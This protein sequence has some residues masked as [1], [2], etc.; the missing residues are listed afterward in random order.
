[1]VTQTIENQT[2][3]VNPGDTVQHDGHWFSVENCVSWWCDEPLS[4][5]KMD[6]AD[7]YLYDW[8]VRPATEEEIMHAQAVAQ[9]ADEKANQERRQKAEEYR[10]QR[11]AYE[12]KLAQLRDQFQSLSKGLTKLSNTPNLANYQHEEIG[13]VAEPGFGASHVIELTRWIDGTGKTV[14]VSW[15]EPC[16]DMG[17]DYWG[18][19]TVRN[20]G[21]AQFR[22][23]QWWKQPGYGD[24]SYPGPG[25]PREELTT[26]E[27]A[28]V[29]KYE[30][31][32]RAELIRRQVLDWKGQLR[33][34]TDHREIL[35]P[36]SGKVELAQNEIVVTLPQSRLSDA[37]KHQLHLQGLAKGNARHAEAQVLPIRFLTCENAP[38]LIRDGG[39]LRLR[40]AGKLGKEVESALRVAGWQYRSKAWAAN[41]TPTAR[42]AAINAIAPVKPEAKTDKLVDAPIYFDDDGRKI[43]IARES[44]LD[45]WCVVVSNLNGQFSVF[46]LNRQSLPEAFNWQIQDF[47]PQSVRSLVEQG[48]NVKP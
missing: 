34:T 9:A 31:A 11:T 10:A 48:F 32:K 28:Q 19:E 26:A 7:G 27:L 33:W 3:P 42:E 8:T 44:D 37:E 22:V 6:G 12:T 24:D 40:E 17:L 36:P 46:D 47:A 13:S 30:A 20:A 14:A 39:T 38:Y 43:A 2:Y 35:S 15:G 5:G 16:G 45:C 21:D 41:D 4:F 25:V 29:E 23:S 1:M 18:N